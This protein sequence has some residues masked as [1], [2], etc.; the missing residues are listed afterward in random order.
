M[1]VENFI[2]KLWSAKL[3]VRLRKALVFAGVVNTD[4]EGEISG[5]GDTVKINEIG[6]I[7]VNDYTRAGSLT[8]QALTSAQ[9]MLLIDQAKYFAFSIDSVDNAQT[10]PK[11]MN[12]AMSEA[13]YA[14]ADTIDAFLAGKYTDAGITD[15]TNLGSAASPL[16]VSSGNVLLAISYLARKMDEANVPSQGRFAIIN[17]WVHQKILLTETGGAAGSTEPKVFD[18]GALTSGYVGNLYGF[19]LLLSNNVQASASNVSAIMAFNRNTISYA[20]QVTTIKAVEREA[21]FDEAVK[22]LYVYGGKVVRPE[23]L[24]VGNFTEVA[25]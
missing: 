7:T 4:Y 9:K 13:S 24:A 19:N 20:G 21:Y 12:G 17:P 15:A 3:L 5:Y 6:N 23:S 14:I 25:G 10:N 18:D 16:S 11:L 22:G 1:G 8:F 2:P